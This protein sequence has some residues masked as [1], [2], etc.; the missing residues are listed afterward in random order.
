MKYSTHYITTIICLVILAL[1]IAVNQRAFGGYE[2]ND[3]LTTNVPTI[4]N[5]QLP[6]LQRQRL[7]TERLVNLATVK[8]NK[9]W[10]GTRCTHIAFN[11]KHL[12]D[13]RIAEAKWFSQARNSRW[14]FDCSITFNTDPRKIRTSFWHYCA[15]VIH[16]YGHLSGF[17]RKGGPNDGLHSSNRNHIMYPVLTE[18]NI[19]NVCKT[20]FVAPIQDYTEPLEVP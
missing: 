17:Y 8:A 4:P 1:A 14:F 13:K 6:P 20:T 15:A 16:E 11:Y 2:G 18:R 3:I 5:Q 12:S 9:F 7:L 19:P 10:D